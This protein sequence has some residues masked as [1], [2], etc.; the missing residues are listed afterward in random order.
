MNY[1]LKEL[2]DQNLSFTSVKSN[3]D[4][5]LLQNEKSKLHSSD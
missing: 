1:Q 2:S 3:F 4:T 5:N